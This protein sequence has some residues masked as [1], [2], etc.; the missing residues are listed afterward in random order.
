MNFFLLVMVAFNFFYSIWL[1]LCLHGCAPYGYLVIRVIRA[2]Q[3]LELGIINSCDPHV[4][5]SNW[6]HIYERPANALYCWVSLL[7]CVDY[8]DQHLYCFYLSICT[9]LNM[10]FPFR[11]I[12]LML[13]CRRAFHVSWRW[14]Q[15]WN[16]YILLWELPVKKTLW[17]LP[18]FSVWLIFA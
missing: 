13:Q 17:F 8:F 3:K 12:L 15:N 11:N 6:A 4:S 10:Q 7:P 9:Y 1:F 14:M 2:S 5:T 16:E 18:I